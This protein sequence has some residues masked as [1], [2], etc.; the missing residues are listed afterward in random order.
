MAEPAFSPRS[1][2]GKKEEDE[3]NPAVLGIQKRDLLR[4]V[5]RE[6]GAA[7]FLVRACLG[8]LTDC[9]PSRSQISRHG[10]ARDRVPGSA[11]EDYLELKSEALEV[12]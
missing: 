3:W 8:D 5:L 2:P 1:K 11:Q 4:E 6:L 12:A 10:A 7:F 9:A